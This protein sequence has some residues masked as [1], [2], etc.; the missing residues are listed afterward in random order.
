VIGS[1]VA[2]VGC[3]RDNREFCPYGANATVT[4][5]IDA[6]PGVGAPCS[7][8]AECIADMTKP[9][10]DTVDMPHACVQCT[11]DD[12]ALCSGTSP[13]CTNHVCAAC[14]ANSECGTGGLCLPSGA[15]AASSNIIHAIA[16][17]GSKDPLVCGAPSSP[18]TLS[19]ALAAVNATRNVIK[20][21]DP[22][23]YTP[24]GGG[25]TVASDVTIDARGASLHRN[26]GGP[27]LTLNNRSVT[28]FAGALRGATGGSGDGIVC[29][30]GGALTLDGTTIEMNENLGVNASGGCKLTMSRSRILSNHGGGI[31]LAS[32]SLSFAIV[33][34][35]F[36]GNGNTS[37]STTASV[38]ISATLNS[39]NRFDFNTVSGNTAQGGIP[40]GVNC[41]A[42]VGF[43]ASGNIIWN[44]LGD[45]SQTAGNCQYSYSAI[46]PTAVV[47][48]GTGNIKDDPMLVDEATDPHLKLGSP[49]IRAADPGADL[50]GL[51]ASDIDGQPR[52]APADMGADQAPR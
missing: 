30:A 17:N 27:I 49:A 24:D 16:T 15:C 38:S 31:T 37:S 32:G 10:C 11:T 6:P 51:A 8:R 29:S 40:A 39:K 35:A 5:C 18:C 28:V 46:G 47:V 50:T 4:G 33:G 48:S 43:V 25:F 45:T 23:T 3:S 12:H 1:V 20:L 26:D 19:T 41:A 36:L 52:V 44:N 34:N 7:S 14:S 13:V 21:D 9:V 2:L 42:G 22:A